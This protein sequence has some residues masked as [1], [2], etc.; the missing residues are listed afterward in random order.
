[1]SRVHRDKLSVA[2]PP[3]AARTPEQQMWA[4][5]LDRWLADLTG[6][7]PAHRAEAMCHLQPGYSAWF[8]T[9]CE[10]AGADPDA[11]RERALVMVGLK[12]GRGGSVRAGR[13]A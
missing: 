8:D 5:S 13:P 10:V 12:T 6:P 1:M 2:L 3:R 4:A 11:V 7:V 9:A